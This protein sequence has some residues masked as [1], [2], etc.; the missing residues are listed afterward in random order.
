MNDNYLWDRT[1]TPD[2]EVQELEELLGTLRYQPRPLEIPTTLK[3]RSNRMVL[4]L[5]IAAAIALTMLAT[6]LWIHFAKSQAGPVIQAIRQDQPIAPSKIETPVPSPDNQTVETVVKR[7]TNPPRHPKTNP[8]LVATSKHSNV[9]LREA[10]LTPQELAEKEQVLVAL[11]LLSAKLNLVQR[12]S[13]GLPQVNAI[14]NQ[15]KMG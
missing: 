6:A 15:H 11:R 12:K 9:Q 2:A 14:R 4:P 5:A 8:V 1:G 7:A 10:A 3:V 13:Q